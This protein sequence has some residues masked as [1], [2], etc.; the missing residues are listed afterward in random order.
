[1]LCAPDNFRKDES[2][3]DFQ[4]SKFADFCRYE[5][6]MHSVVDRMREIRRTLFDYF[7]E[8]NGKW[9][10]YATSQFISCVREYGGEPDDFD[11]NGEILRCP[12]DE[13]LEHFCVIGDLY[14][15]DWR[16]IVQDTTEEDI[17]RMIVDLISISEVDITEGYKKAFGRN[18]QIYKNTDGVMRKVDNME[19]SLDLVNQQVEAEDLSTA[20]RAIFTGIALTLKII[21]SC[22]YNDDNTERLKMVERMVDSLM[23]MDFD[24]IL[25]DAKTYLKKE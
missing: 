15:N 24:K 6:W 18:L 14:K 4:D 19:H 10:Y 23:S 13:K 17:N 22:P 9:R 7:S 5:V 21:K 8:F 1:M 2:I 25:D 3:A 11:E 20:L 12:P 16:D